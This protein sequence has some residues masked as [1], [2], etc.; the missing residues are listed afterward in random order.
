MTACIPHVV[1]RLW[2]NSSPMK[3]QSHRPLKA[4]RL[5]TVILLLTTSAVSIS[6]SLPTHATGPYADSL[7]T[8]IINAQGLGPL[9]A[10]HLFVD[11][12]WDLGQIR[13]AFNTAN[14]SP[15]DQTAVTAARAAGLKVILEFD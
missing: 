12:T 13:Q 10:A 11:R 5:L 15:G 7:P 6:L 1:G 8:P 4:R 9:N 2:C 14:I 3:R